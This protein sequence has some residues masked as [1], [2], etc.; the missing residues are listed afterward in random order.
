MSTHNI[1]FHEEMQKISVLFKKVD[2][3]SSWKLSP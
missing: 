1:F 3:D 2:F